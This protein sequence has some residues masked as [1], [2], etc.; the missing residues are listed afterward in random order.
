MPRWM[1]GS[2]VR[3]TESGYILRGAR[4]ITS[5]PGEKTSE[6]GVAEV[7]PQ[8]KARLPGDPARPITSGSSSVRSPTRPQSFAP[9]TWLMHCDVPCTG[10]NFLDSAGRGM[11]QGSGRGCKTTRPLGR[12]HHAASRGFELRA[13]AWRPRCNQRGGTPCACASQGGLWEPFRQISSLQHRI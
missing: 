11:V 5:G 8:A 13:I 3:V 9:L 6:N 7:T 4:R 1:L 10:R 12:P 2:L